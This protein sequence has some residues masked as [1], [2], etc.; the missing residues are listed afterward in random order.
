MKNNLILI[1]VFTALGAVA[2]LSFRK[3]SRK[4]TLE[5]L[6]LNFS[7]SDTASIDRILI[8]RVNGKAADLRRMKEGYW[9]LNGKYKAAPV[10]MDVLLTTVRNVEMLRPLSRNEALTAIESFEKRGKKVT[11][12]VNGEAYKSYQLGDDAP[13]NRGTYVRLEGGD[14]YVAYLRSFNGFL[15]PRYDVSENEWRDRLLF[16]CPAEKIRMLKLIYAKMPAENL[17][18]S[19]SGHQL[20]LEG[21][22][23]FDTAA[24]LGIL[25]SFRR[26][27][28]ERY[29]ERL[30]ARQKD[31]LLKAGYEYAIE[32]QGE[33]KECTAR[34]QLFFTSD[35]DRSLAYNPDT[36]EWLT[37]QNRGLY[38]ILQRK[39]ALLNR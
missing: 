31:S 19:V 16:S 12:F 34:L 2:W 33:D 39:T 17:Q 36:Q 18:L 21:A 37:I 5:K 26:V 6:D 8:E 22:T 32:I 10:L 1:F 11:I 27:F 30:P 38:P 25:Q 35:P 28:A 3:V 23:S 24:A 20:H 7:V 14:P 9:M 13:G 4:S 15:S 29:L